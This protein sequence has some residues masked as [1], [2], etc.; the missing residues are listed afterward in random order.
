MV[1]FM[2]NEGF[3]PGT[4]TLI[5]CF[6][7]GLVRKEKGDAMRLEGGDLVAFDD[8]ESMYDG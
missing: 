4:N 1:V 7:C 8:C 3:G 6:G 5:K 2:R